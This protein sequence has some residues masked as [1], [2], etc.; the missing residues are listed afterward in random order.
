PSLTEVIV[1]G[2]GCA[3]IAAA[4]LADQVWFDR[5]F[6]P[7]FW[8]PREEIVQT[9]QR[10]RLGVAIAGAVIVL[11]LRKPIARGLGRDPLYLFTIALAVALAI[12]TAETVLRIRAANKSPEL[13]D[14]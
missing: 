12:G 4:L 13:A 6:L 5:H 14:P 9:E 8:T 3:V 2:I 7:S 1:G 10:V 11:L